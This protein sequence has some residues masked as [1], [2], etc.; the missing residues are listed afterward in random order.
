[1]VSDYQRLT[2][3]G[4]GGERVFAYVTDLDNLPNYVDRMVAVKRV[5]GTA[6]EGVVRVTARIGA[7]DGGRTV[8]G[9]AWYRVDRIAWRVEWGSNGADDY[10]GTVDVTPD[11]D[12][13]QVE[14]TLHTT[15]GDTDRITSSLD[16]TLDRLR[17]LLE[18]SG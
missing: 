18:V 6:D 8:E 4:A 11:Q 16:A 9:E 1:M 10:R 13:T 2:S 5:E 14:I 3:V 7:G 17:E 12:R 15:S